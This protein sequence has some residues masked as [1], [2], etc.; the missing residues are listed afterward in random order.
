MCHHAQLFF[1][2]STLVFEIGSLLE[3]EAYEFGKPGSLENVLIRAY[4]CN[5]KQ[6]E[7][8]RVYFA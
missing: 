2:F 8:K 4:C 3:P 5:Q 7:E 1:F 6:L